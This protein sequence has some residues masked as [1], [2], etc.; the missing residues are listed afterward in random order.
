MALNRPLYGW[1]WT[2][3][4]RCLTLYRPTQ[5]WMYVPCDKL[6]KVVGRPRL[7]VALGVGIR[8]PDTWRFLCN[9]RASLD[10]SFKQKSGFPHSGGVVA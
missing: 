4:T 6:A 1:S 10:F 3:G 5:G 7:R 8:D 9:S 2:R